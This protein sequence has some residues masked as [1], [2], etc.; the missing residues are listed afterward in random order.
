VNRKQ[1]RAFAE[2]DFVARHENLVFQG[3]TDPA[4]FYTSLLH[5]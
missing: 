2:L 5:C 4:T 3:P 1:I